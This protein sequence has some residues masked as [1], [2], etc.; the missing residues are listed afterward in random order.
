LV[1]EETQINKVWNAFITHEFSINCL[2]NLAQFACW[3]L[4]P[5][6]Y[7][8]LAMSCDLL[9]EPVLFSGTLRSNLDPLTQYSDNEIWNALEHAHLKN[10]FK[11]NLPG[12]L[13]YIVSN[14]EFR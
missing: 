3:L 5:D 4:K 10:F 8:I 7:S 14:E 13:L 1:P 11:E 9:Q 2:F 12:G 6:N